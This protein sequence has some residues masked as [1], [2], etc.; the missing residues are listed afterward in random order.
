MYSSRNFNRF[1]ELYSYHHNPILE[2]FHYCKKKPHAYLQQLPIP[3]PRPWQLLI[4]FLSIYIYIYIFFFFLNF[5]L[6]WVFIAAHGLSLVE[7][8]G[9]HSSLWC[10]SFSLW[11]LLLLC[12]TGSRRTGSVV[13]VH[14]LSRSTACGIFPDQGLNLCPLHWQADSQPLR[15]QGSHLSIYLPFLNISYK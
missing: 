4:Y 9:G 13:V 1:T 5:W 12:I 3:T 2:H 6:H 7:A 8:S 14:G 15:H 10:A 11:W